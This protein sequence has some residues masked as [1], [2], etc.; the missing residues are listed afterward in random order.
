MK[1][2][3]ILIEPLPAGGHAAALVVDGRLQDLLL[4]PPDADPTPRPEAIH[5]G[6]AA[7]PMKGLGGVIVDLGGG[8]TGFL[9]SKRP[10]APGRPLMVQVGGWAEPGKA[11]PVGER[12]RLKGTGAV[13]TPGA[14]GINVSRA[15]R[16]EETRAALADLAAAAMAGADHDLG[17]IL[18]T[19]AGVM[20]AEAIRDEIAALRADWA[21]LAAATS[22]PPACLREGPGAAETALRE[23]DG[24]DTDLVEGAKVFG[25]A[26]LWEEIEALRAPHVPLGAG[27][28]SVEPTRALVAIDVNTGSDLTPAAALKANLAAARE[29][30]RQLRLRGLGGQ[31]VIDFAPLTRAERPRIEQALSAALREDGIDTTL[32]GWTP[33]GHLELTRRRTR[34]PLGA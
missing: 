15:I 2:R 20:R 13:L 27:F 5:R 24:P 11:P 16:D 23:W 29:L 18:R 8:Q 17:L 26:G 21:R 12:L 32:A 6:T 3:Q 4:D 10:P 25:D 1:G 19:R 28:M 22:G 7:R 30:P 33:L 14:P 31:V 9:R 34:R